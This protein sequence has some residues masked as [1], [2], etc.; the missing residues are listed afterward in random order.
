MKHFAA[1]SVKC[2]R[3]VRPLD[4]AEVEYDEVLKGKNFVNNLQNE[5]YKTL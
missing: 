4:G 1:F 3:D 5:A 2:A